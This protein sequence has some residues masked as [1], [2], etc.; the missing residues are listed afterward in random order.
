MI[1][2]YFQSCIEH[3]ERIFKLPFHYSIERQ[4]G[5]QTSYSSRLFSDYPE[6]PILIK[7]GL[8]PLLGSD[9]QRVLSLF[10]LFLVENSQKRIAPI[11]GG[12]IAAIMVG[13]LD[14]HANTHMP[15]YMCTY[16]HTYIYKINTSREEQRVHHIE[17]PLFLHDYLV[18]LV[19][20]RTWVRFWT[21]T[22]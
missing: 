21:H 20:H 6:V 7:G 1:I 10:P 11:E 14:G 5:M 22:V 4:V 13:K 9:L 8:E 19:L 3:G 18:F 15:T 16:A 17:G 12:K 2:Q